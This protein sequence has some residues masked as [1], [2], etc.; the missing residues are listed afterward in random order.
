[1]CRFLRVAPTT[2][3]GETEL[4]ESTQTHSKYAV[5]TMEV[6][7]KGD[8]KGKFVRFTDANATREHAGHFLALVC[9]LA[10]G[11]RHRDIR[12]L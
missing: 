6:Q 10:V 8:A 2:R 5:R 7:E 11:V 1:M 3:K 12:V 9:G 4:P